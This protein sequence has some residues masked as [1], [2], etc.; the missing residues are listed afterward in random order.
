M[1]IFNRFVAEA[2]ALGAELALVADG[3]AR[4]DV[5]A[6][7]AEWAAEAAAVRPEIVD[8]A[9]VFEAEGARHSVVEASL[10]AQGQGFTANDC[11]LDARGS[12]APRLTLITGPNMAGKSTF[13]RQNVLLVILAQAGCYVPAR[14]FRLGLADRVFSSCGRIRRSVARAVDLHG[15]DDR[16]GGDPEPGD[17]ELDRDPR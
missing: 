14:K 2:D 13:L 5:A 3:L 11:R 7:N 16:D 6:G 4:I 1:D 17:A 10:R 15:R 8:N 12:S 9:P